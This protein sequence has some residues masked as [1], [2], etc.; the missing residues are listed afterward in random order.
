[1]ICL[2][3][4]VAL[5]DCV[6]CKGSGRENVLGGFQPCRRCN[7]IGNI[8]DH[9]VSD[10]KCNYC[11]GTARV[12][13]L[14]GY[15]M[16][17]ICQG[18]GYMPATGPTLP[19]ALYVSGKQPEEARQELSTA[20]ES[21]RGE[22]RVCD[23]YYGLGMLSKL[24]SLKKCSRVRVLTRR[25][26]GP[27]SVAA[28]EMQDFKKY[29]P[30]MQ[31]KKHAG[32]GLHDRYILSRDQLLLLGQS[33][34][35]FGGSESFVVVLSKEIAGDITKSVRGSFDEKWKLASLLA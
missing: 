15:A 34:K 17:R 7:G 20:L 4:D 21:L 16:C 30:K 3:E 13:T 32:G 8:P 23:Q 25:L 28:H 19:L 2:Q 18:F 14:G 5:M 27:D 12:Q 9:L 33:L 35:D 24:R 11:N 26:G 10:Q 31:F 22:V 6:L 29:Y 1:M